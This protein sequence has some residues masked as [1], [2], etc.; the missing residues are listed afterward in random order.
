MNAFILTR[1]GDII[2]LFA[3]KDNKMFYSKD[4][5]YPYSLVL[6][7]PLSNVDSNN[8]TISKKLLE[9]ISINCILKGDIIKCVIYVDIENETYLVVTQS[10]I[11]YNYAYGSM[12]KSER[13]IE[14]EQIRNSI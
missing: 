1:T 10:N 5:K 9:D 8:K 7:K 14:N 6:D 3:S 4:M 11:V 13:R 12:Y 2:E